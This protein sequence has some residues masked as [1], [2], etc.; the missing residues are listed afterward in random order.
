VLTVDPETKVPRLARGS[1]DATTDPKAVRN[2]WR[3][4]ADAGVAIATGHELRSGGRLIVL[5]VDPRNGG[6]ESLPKLDPMGGSVR[7]WR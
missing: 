1:H 3:L 6:M 2:L 4:A 5:D 7:A